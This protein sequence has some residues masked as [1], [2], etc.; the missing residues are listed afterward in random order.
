[1]DGYYEGYELNDYIQEWMLS[2]KGKLV[3]SCGLRIVE[4]RES[5]RQCSKEMMLSKSTV[6]RY[7]KQELPQISYELYRCCLKQLVINKKKYFKAS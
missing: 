7:I 5:I 6:H 3:L 1:M 4:Y 2:D